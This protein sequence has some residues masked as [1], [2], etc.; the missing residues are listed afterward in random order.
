MEQIVRN[1]KYY[2]KQLND[3]FTYITPLFYYNIFFV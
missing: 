2:V 3:T 1:K